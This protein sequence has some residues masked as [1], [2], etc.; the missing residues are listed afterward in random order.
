MS[1]ASW[2]CS[3][4]LYVSSLFKP[5][6]LN[7][8][9][10]FMF[11]AWVNIF[12]VSVTCLCLNLW[13]PRLSKSTDKISYDIPPNE[14]K[15]G[16][17]RLWLYSRRMFQDFGIESG[18]ATNMLGALL[19]MTVIIDTSLQWVSRELCKI[20]SNR[21]SVIYPPLFWSTLSMCPW[22]LGQGCIMCSRNISIHIQTPWLPRLH[23]A[24]HM[25]CYYYLY[26]F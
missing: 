21:V 17:S 11:G 26:L 18:R 24:D 8:S 16:Q 1:K 9:S 23:K 22:L 15:C 19:I 14:A 3:H 6:G 25:V 5:A 4:A 20:E 12:T 13:V 2:I 7:S 10:I